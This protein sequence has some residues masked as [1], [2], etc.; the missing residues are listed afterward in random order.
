MYV[1]TYVCAQTCTNT[2]HLLA[3]MDGCVCL[4]CCESSFPVE[5]QNEHTQTLIFI[6]MVVFLGKTRN[7]RMY[8]HY[9]NN[10]HALAFTP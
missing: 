10:K 5:M 9:N 3:V 2:F 7:Y 4:F 1:H 6:I 8:A